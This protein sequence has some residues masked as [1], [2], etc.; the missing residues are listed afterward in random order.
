MENQV[1]AER[2]LLEY[3][4]SGLQGCVPGR[5]RKNSKPQM[6]TTVSVGSYRGS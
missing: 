5:H 2:G 3:V 6:E 4:R 1:D